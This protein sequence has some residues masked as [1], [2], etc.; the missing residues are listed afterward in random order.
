MN[1]KKVIS[2]G[3]ALLIMSHPVFPC[4]GIT[5]TSK[6]GGIV[7]A[8]T[9]EWALSDAQHNKIL[10]V[11][12]GKEF[13]GQ[14]P[15]GYNGKVWSGKYG[16]VT[17][18]AYGQNYGPDGLNE[19]GLYVG[20]YYLPDFAKYA[21]YD[22]NNAHNSMSVGDFMQWMLSSFKT[23][24]EVINNLDEVTIVEVKNEDFGGAD[25]PFHFKIADPQ[26]DSKIIEIVNNGEIKVYEPYL[27]VITNSPTY[28]WHITNQRN[29]LGLT[30]QPQQPLSFAPYDLKPLGGGS[31]LLG[32]PGDFTP[33]SR[34]TRAAAFTASCRPL[35]TS[36]DAVF[37][38]FRILDN[39]NIPI[40]AQIPSDYLPDDIVGATQITTASDL[41]NKVFYYHTMWNRQIRKIDLNAIDF[42]T[43]EE[44]IIDDDAQKM[45]NMKDVTPN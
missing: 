14:T 8:R 32:L 25:L 37:E 31:G 29:Y 3:L 44:Q 28:D 23:V 30:T 15:E 34:F 6:D 16:F 43:V 38:S 11:P 1:L 7:A 4:T 39:F 42:A 33:P 36:L 12:R 35:E 26:G 9:V 19:E 10:V 45:N 22:S 13:T 18:T 40:G 20:V 41:K 17:L 24:E 27:G 2:I 21:I 5:L